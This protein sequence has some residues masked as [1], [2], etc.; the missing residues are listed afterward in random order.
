MDCT[1]SLHS[2]NLSSTGAW[3]FVISHLVAQAEQAAQLWMAEVFLAQEVG[4]HLA[5]HPSCFLCFLW[6]ELGEQFFSPSV[7][8]RD[9]AQCNM[10]TKM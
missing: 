2:H 9:G 4:S 6:V 7:S 8:P 1:S 10:C 3:D 5:R